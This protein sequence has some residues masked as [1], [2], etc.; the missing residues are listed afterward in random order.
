MCKSANQECCGMVVETKRVFCA[1]SVITDKKCDSIFLLSERKKFASIYRITALHML[2]FILRAKD[3]LLT[4][5]HCSLCTFS[6]FVLGRSAALRSIY[7]EE[8]P[9]VAAHDSLFVL[10]RRV[11]LRSCTARHGNSWAQ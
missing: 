5:I 2:H 10:L 7:T 4:I 3:F 1:E 11:I 8:F 9:G 6:S